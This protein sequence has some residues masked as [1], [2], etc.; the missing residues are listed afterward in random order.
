[1][2]QTYGIGIIP[3]S[4][5]AGGFL[6][7]KYQRDAP[8]PADSRFE[9]YWKGAEKRH[10]SEA[11]WAV[12]DLVAELSKEKDCT[13]YQL[14]LAWVAQQPGVTSPIIG[15]RTKDHLVDS[16]QAVNV[17]LTAQDLERIDAVSPPGR[18][19]VP[20]YGYD[21]MAWVKWGPHRFRW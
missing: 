10:R 8:P 20:Y 13:P 21:G 16:V 15:P 5:T 4:P 9:E 12:L 18:A 17:Q 19:I 11:A 3:W 7:G 14:A 1:M 6:T 2:A